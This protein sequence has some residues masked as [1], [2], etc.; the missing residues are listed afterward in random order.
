MTAAPPSAATR[1]QTE[2]RAAGDAGPAASAPAAVARL[3]RAVAVRRRVG[4][5]SLAGRR[6]AVRGRVSAGAS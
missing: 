4:E 5:A 2:R 6:A 1:P 3:G